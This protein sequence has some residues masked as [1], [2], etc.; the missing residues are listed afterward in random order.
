MYYF[1]KLIQATGL[2]IIFIGFIQK[3]PQLMSPKTILLGITVFTSGWII[4]KFLLKGK[5]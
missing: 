5:S 4:Q 2:I 3:F 1:S